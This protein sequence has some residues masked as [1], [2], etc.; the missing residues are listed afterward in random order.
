MDIREK[1]ADRLHPGVAAVVFDSAREQVLLQKR[2]DNGMWGLPSGHV[3]IGETVEEAVIREVKE[4]TG[5]QVKVVRLVGVYSDPS[6]QV[7]SYPTG[8]RVHFITT[9]FECLPV[10]G[11]LSPDMVESRDVKF[12]HF[13]NL[14]ANILPMHPRWLH[15]S[16]CG[17]DAAFIR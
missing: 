15:D 6:S 8:E 4:E 13:G 10:G 16:L 12:F 7:F 14:P 1:P 11:S 3:E 17:Q 5:L 2:S 9:F